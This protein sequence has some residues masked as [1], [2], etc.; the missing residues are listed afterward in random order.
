MFRCHD[1]IGKLWFFSL[2]FGK[3]R[4]F[5]FNNESEVL[6][7]SEFRLGETR[8]LG[9][10]FGALRHIRLGEPESA[11]LS[12]GSGKS[13]SER[14]ATTCNCPLASMHCAVIDPIVCDCK[15][16]NRARR[17]LEPRAGPTRGLGGQTSVQLSLLNH[18]Y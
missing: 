10:K 16:S 2:R 8:I 3:G 12:P 6:K 17:K 1:L 11:T 9:F 13:L 7:H 15:Y 14:H 18:A 5:A 4:D